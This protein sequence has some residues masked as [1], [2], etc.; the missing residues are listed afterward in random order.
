LPSDGRVLIQIQFEQKINRRW[1]AVTFGVEHV[2]HTDT[3]VEVTYP[4]HPAV[5]D[6]DGVVDSEE[7]EMTRTTWRRAR[8]FKPWEGRAIEIGDLAGYD[9]ASSQYQ[10]LSILLNDTDLGQKLQTRSA[11]EIAASQV[12]PGDPGGPARAKRVTVAGGYGSKPDEIAR[13]TGL[14]V[15]EARAVLSAISP[16][17]E[18]FRNY[19][20]KIAWAVPQYEGFTFTDPFDQSRVTWYPVRVSER[21]I[22][23][24]TAGESYKLKTYV[25][26]DLL[27][28]EGRAPVNPYKLQQELAPMLVHAMDSAFSGFVIEEL[29]NRGVQTVV[30]LFDCWLVHESNKDKLKAA[31][32]AAGEPR[33]RSLQSVYDGLLDP[34]YS[35]PKKHRRW[36]ENCAEAYKQRV[37]ASECG[38]RPWPVLR[39]RHLELARW[40]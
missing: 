24:N 28:A 16:S 34:R 32:T 22:R 10:I 27:N 4:A 21:E 8:M 3:D 37:S 18:T 38:E 39:T 20:R 25:P 35:V 1:H 15:E 30:A 7:P 6:E 26:T 19:A 5:V 12:W 17:I 11:H 36:M 31:I 29:V 9:V 14:T 13:K 40:D 33:L 23:S 2:G